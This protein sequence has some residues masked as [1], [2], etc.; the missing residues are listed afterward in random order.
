LVWGQNRV[1]VLARLSRE[2]PEQVRAS[3][4]ELAAIVQPILL[5]TIQNPGEIDFAGQTLPLLH[6]SDELILARISQVLFDLAMS[7]SESLGKAAFAALM[8]DIEQLITVERNALS[9]VND[10]NTVLHLLPTL[11]SPA[12]LHRLQYLQSILHAH[13][14]ALS[15]NLDRIND[16]ETANFALTTDDWRAFRGSLDK[17]LLPL[18]FYQIRLLLGLRRRLKRRHARSRLSGLIG[19][20][21]PTIPTSQTYC[22]NRN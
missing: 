11:P 16:I 8:A 15:H 14:V 17:R 21:Y 12:I 1:E 6:P 5:K 3:N 20:L 4:D 10:M 22:K 9:P 13:V 7:D 19:I 2:A 18:L